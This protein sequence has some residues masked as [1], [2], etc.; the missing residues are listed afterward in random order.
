MFTCGIE[1]GVDLVLNPTGNSWQVNG[2]TLGTANLKKGDPTPSYVTVLPWPSCLSMAITKLCPNNKDLR[3]G[4]RGAGGA[5]EAP[6]PF[7]FSSARGAKRRGAAGGPARLLGW[8]V[9]DAGRSH[10]LGLLTQPLRTL[11]Y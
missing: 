9:W 8:I 4:P 1:L 6:G 11:G 10:G 5:S 3:W 7:A 2:T